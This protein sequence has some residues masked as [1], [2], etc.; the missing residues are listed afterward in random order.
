MVGESNSH[1]K[2]G[3]SYAEWFRRMRPLIIERDQ[4][5]R[6]CGEIKPDI[7]VKRRDRGEP[8]RRSQMSV[9]HIDEDPTN[10]RPNNL[11]YVCQSCHIK[12]HR[13]VPT[14]FPWF[15]KYAASAT[16][17]M[18]ATWLAEVAALRAKFGARP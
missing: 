2:D 9:H 7:Y 18:S 5:C 17:E 14:P 4:C 12:H 11:I 15:G 1:Y 8:Q 10:N 6:A 16:L 13:S 3:T